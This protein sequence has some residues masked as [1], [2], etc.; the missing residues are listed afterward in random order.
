MPIDFVHMNGDSFEDMCAALFQA[1][2]G[3]IPIKANPGD[4][5]IDS[6]R[7][8]LLEGVSHIWQY[9]HFPDGIGEAQKGQIRKSL[10]TAIK[11]YHPKRWTLV[12]PCDLDAGAQKWLEKQQVEFAEQGT[13]VDYIGAAELKNLLL[14]HQAIRQEYFPN[15]D[16]QLKVVAALLG[17]KDKLFEQPK[18]SIL[19]LMQS[20]VVSVNADSPDWGYRISGDER[21]QTIEAFLRNPNA[22]DATAME[23]DLLMPNDPEGRQVRKDW[24]DAHKKGLPFSVDGKHV[25][26]KRWVFEGLVGKDF[27]LARMEL[28][29]HVPDRR[30]PMRLT[31]TGKSG[32]TATLPLVDF[33]LKREGAEEMLF[34][35]DEQDIL[36]TIGL[37]TGISGG[38][39]NFKTRD[40]VGRM[41]S[42]VVRCEEVLSVVAEGEAHVEMEHVETGKRIGAAVLTQGKGD[43]L[44]DF[45]LLP[46]YRNLA[47]VE[48]LLDPSL[49][50]PETYR[51]GDLAAAAY[52]AKLLTDGEL[53]ADG[54]ASLTMTVSNAD[55]VRAAVAGAEMYAVTLAETTEEVLL[56]GRTYA[57]D[58]TTSIAAPLILT[59]ATAEELV[60]GA[61]IAVK[62]EGEV[63]RVFTNGRVVP[64]SEAG[65]TGQKDDVI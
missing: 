55:G 49:R 65:A 32:A 46:F 29:P 15:T 45:E 2:H 30:V 7:G 25:A 5:G 63:V 10:K 47:T 57:F 18:A 23:F 16:D 8:S 58:V 3:A 24:V 12:I 40:Y 36:L 22:K 51:D 39:L 31:F 52:L 20:G 43:N 61:T 26:I 6:F 4:G 17:G 48:A 60:D 38:V 64:T 1:E 28:V 11:N 14:K 56:F 59:D 13:E 9:K 37:N 42:E 54:T 21:G 27:T 33:R 50:M 19:D 53:R 44:P 34:T 62:Q 35:N 41:P